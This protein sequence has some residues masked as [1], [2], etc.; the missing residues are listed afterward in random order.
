MAAQPEIVEVAKWSSQRFRPLFRTGIVL[1][2][3]LASQVGLPLIASLVIWEEAGVPI[4]AEAAG[5]GP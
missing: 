3:D 4:F 1:V 2:F 5:V